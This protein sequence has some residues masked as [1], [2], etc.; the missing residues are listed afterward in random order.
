MSF[1]A[2]FVC[3]V[4]ATASALFFAALCLDDDEDFR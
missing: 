2:G 4:V 1:V 3:G